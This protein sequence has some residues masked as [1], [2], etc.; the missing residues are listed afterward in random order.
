MEWE[1]KV[2]DIFGAPY[3]IKICLKNL[4]MVCNN[5]FAYVNQKL[6]TGNRSREIWLWFFDMIVS[7]T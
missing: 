4:H 1:Q 7:G 3:S 6:A 2:E 5:R